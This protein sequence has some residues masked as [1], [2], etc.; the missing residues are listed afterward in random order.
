MSI[1]DPNSPEYVPTPKPK[2]AGTVH[3]LV[4]ANAAKPKKAPRGVGIVY[5]AD[6]TPRISA[7]WVNNLSAEHRKWAEQDLRAHGYQLT[8]DGEV[9]KL[10]T[11]GSQ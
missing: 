5:A 8:A 2:V 11:E 6:G 3:P 10:N 4:A 9:Q 7:D 1:N